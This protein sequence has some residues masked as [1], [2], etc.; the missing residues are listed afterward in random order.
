MSDDKNQYIA[1]IKNYGIR[2]GGG[3]QRREFSNYLCI[4]NDFECEIKNSIYIYVICL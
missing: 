3:L 1:S 2:R 4:N